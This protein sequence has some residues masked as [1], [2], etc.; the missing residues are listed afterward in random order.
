[1]IENT[2]KIYT[3]L[4]FC[5]SIKTGLKTHY[6][7]T[8]N[9]DRVYNV[10]I[11]LQLGLDAQKV[12]KHCGRRLNLAVT[13]DLPRTSFYRVISKS[14]CSFVMANSSFGSYSMISLVQ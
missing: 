1:M 6:N 7:W 12:E 2:S 3:L 5:N 13:F 9:C 4:V 11:Y 14:D 10:K 8:K